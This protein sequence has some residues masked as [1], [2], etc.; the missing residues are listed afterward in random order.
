MSLAGA[1]AKHAL[2][3]LSP[4][5]VQL[6]GSGRAPRLAL[7]FD[8]GP[9]PEHTPRILDAL[10]HAGAR[11][12]FFVQGDNAARHPALVRELHARGH[13]VANHAASHRRPRELGAEAYVREVADTQRLLDDIVGRALPRRFRP[14]F[15]DTSL[16]TLA[17][18][19]REGFRFVYWSRDSRDSW[20]RTPE[21]LHGDFEARPPAP[22]DIV[23]FH[24]DYAHTAAALPGLLEGLRRRKLA[25]VTV[26]D[27]P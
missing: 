24:D 27:L 25:A 11:A 9:H 5:R 18:L 23:L 20:L 1:I 3:A 22:G 8:D 10:E 14:P 4:R 2:A 26:E 6:R 12:S 7:T 17:R 21:A 15:G 16:R 19:S 13:L